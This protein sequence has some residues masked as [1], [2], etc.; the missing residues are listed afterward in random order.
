MKRKLPCLRESQARIHSVY[1]CELTQSWAPGAIFLTTRC[2]RS[3]SQSILSFLSPIP[4][5][6]VNLWI[7]QILVAGHETSSTVVVWTA[8]ELARR[9]D[10]QTRLREEIL[11]KSAQVQ[12]R[13]DAEWTW[14]DLEDMPYLTAVIK[15][16]NSYRLV[17]TTY[18]PFFHCAGGATVPNSSPT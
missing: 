17:M 4:K 8:F 7:R 6:D 13:A 2:T 15:V 5:F 12:R 14:K 18:V 11:T 10:V 1:V 9:P 16:R 3:C